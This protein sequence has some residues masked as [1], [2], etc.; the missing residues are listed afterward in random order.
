M[1][2]LRVATYEITAG[3]FDEIAGRS[4]DG[5]LPKFQGEPGFIRYGIADVGDK[6]CVSISL[7]ETREQADHAIPVAA[8]WVRENLA[9]KLSLKT[10]YVGDL[11]FFKGALDT[12]AV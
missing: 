3:T 8:T 11:A 6:M 10:D 2:H 12:V 9:D 7:W 4:K 1:K 5:M